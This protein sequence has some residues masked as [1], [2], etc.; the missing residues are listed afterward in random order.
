MNP[1]R[2]SRCHLSQIR[3]TLAL[4]FLVWLLG[5]SFAVL[6]TLRLTGSFCTESTLGI[7][8]DYIRWG[9]VLM[10]LFTLIHQMLIFYT[11]HK[12]EERDNEFNNLYSRWIGTDLE[13]ILRLLAI[14]IILCVGGELPN[15]YWFNILKAV[16]PIPNWVYPLSSLV[17][18][19]TLFIWDCVALALSDGRHPIRELIRHPLIG[20][21]A[22]FWSDLLGLIYFVFILTAALTN[23]LNALGTIFMLG[24]LS[25]YGAVIVSRVFAYTK[26]KKDRVEI[27]EAATVSPNG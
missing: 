18:F 10:S 20:E 23:H 4:S 15:V 14:G 22:F 5:A 16:P 17:L 12:L 25:L 24:T 27:V 2:K 8:K 7:L 6:E 11:I 9:L 19:A 1:A 21:R 13:V 26:R 3:P